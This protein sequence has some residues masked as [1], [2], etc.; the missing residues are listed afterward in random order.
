MKSSVTISFLL[1]GALNFYQVCAA[2]KENVMLN[3]VFNYQGSMPIKDDRAEEV[4]RPEVNS[5]EL[6]IDSAADLEAAEAACWKL[7]NEQSG[8]YKMPQM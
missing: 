5:T 7:L 1:V 8:M 3:K 6:S 2:P 4:I